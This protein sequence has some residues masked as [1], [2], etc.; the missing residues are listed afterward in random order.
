MSETTDAEQGSEGSLRCSRC[1]TVSRD[2]EAALKDHSGCP[3]S[4]KWEIGGHNWE[5]I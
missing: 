4:K 3:E 2:G 1:G 5:E